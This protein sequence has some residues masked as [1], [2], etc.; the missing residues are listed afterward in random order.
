MRALLPGI[1]RNRENADPIQRIPLSP[2][3]T[4]SGRVP[5]LEMYAPGT[6]P[7]DEEAD[8][9]LPSADDA[10]TLLRKVAEVLAKPRNR[11]HGAS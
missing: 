1:D 3:I 10:D 6:T 7:A 9:Q 4:A 2:T 11:R 8:E 5:I